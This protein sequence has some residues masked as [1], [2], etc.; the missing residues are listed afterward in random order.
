MEEAKRKDARPVAAARIAASELRAHR[1]PE[2]VRSFDE[3]ALSYLLEGPAPQKET[4]S[5]REDLLQVLYDLDRWNDA[6]VVAEELARE[7]PSNVDYLG[8]RGVL[9]VRRG[10][11]EEA[12]GIASQI[13]A[14]EISYDGGNSTFW[15]AR[16][17]ALLGEKDQAVSLLREAH[18]Q[19]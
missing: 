10:G 11:K 15:R 16:I 19:G 6:E 12:R 5:Y 14:M 7:D 8:Y 3:K 9:A 4:V 2:A 18:R 1:H 17:A 13:A